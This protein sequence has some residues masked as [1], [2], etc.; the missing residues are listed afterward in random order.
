MWGKFWFGADRQARDAG[1]RDLDLRDAGGAAPM[2][3]QASRVDR[4][5]LTED[6]AGE[7]AEFLA[8]VYTHQQC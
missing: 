7:I 6:Q 4:T 2:P 3:E 5:P 8:R 1:G